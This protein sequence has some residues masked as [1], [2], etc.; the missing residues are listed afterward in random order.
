MKNNLKLHRSSAVTSNVSSDSIFKEKPTLKIFCKT[1]R[2]PIDCII[3]KIGGGFSWMLFLISPI[4]FFA[5]PKQQTKVGINQKQNET[6]AK[7]KGISNDSL[8]GF[9]DAE[10]D[11]LLKANQVKGAE[12]QNYINTV[13]RNY[14]NKK[15][16]LLQSAASKTS[17]NDNLGGS[18]Y[19]NPN[20]GNSKTAAPPCVNEGFESSPLGLIPLPQTT[21]GWSV[22]WANVVLSNNCIATSAMGWSPGSQKMFIKSTPLTNPIPAM[23]ALFNGS[24]GNSPLGGTRVAQLHDLSLTN[25]RTRIR[26]TIQVTNLNTLFQF[27]FAGAYE[28]GLHRCCEQPGL[29]VR[30]YDC[31]Q[32]AVPCA[33]LQVFPYGNCANGAGTP[34]KCANCASPSNPSSPD[35]YW[36]NWQSY[37]MDLTPYIGTCVTIEFINSDC[38][39]GGHASTT[40]IDCLCGGPLLATKVLNVGGAINV[41]PTATNICKGSGVTLSASGASSYTWSNQAIN[42]GSS[43]NITVFPNANTTYVVNANSNGCV[44]SKNVQVNVIPSVTVNIGDSGTNICAGKCTTLTALSNVVATTFTWTAPFVTNAASIVACPNTTTTYSLVGRAPNGCRGSQ[45]KTVTVNPAPVVTASG[46]PSVICAGSPATVTASGANT[47]NWS[48]ISSSS[49]VVQVF[50]SAT[51]VYTATGTGTNGCSSTATV[52]IN[53]LVTPTAVIQPACICPGIT[54]TLIGMGGMTYTWYVGGTSPATITGATFTMN[55]NASTPFTL[56]ASGANGCKACTAAIIPTCGPIPLVAP[57]VTLC[58]NAGSCTNIAVNTAASPVNFTWLGSAINGSANG[59]TI[60]ICPSVAGVY[61]VNASSTS[62]AG[63]PNSATLAVTIASNCCSQPTAGLTQLSA[64][65]GSL[66]GSFLLNSS[67]SL[68]GSTWFKDA[69]IWIT[70]NVSLKI[71]PGKKLYLDKVHLYACGIKMW[72]GIIVMDGGLIATSSATV[73]RPSNNSMIEDAKIAIQLDNISTTNTWPAYPID[74]QNVIFNKNHIGIKISNSAVTLDSLA[75]RINGCVF[76]SRTMTFT[77]FPNP[78]LSWPS[79]IITGPADLRAP[80][81]AIAGLS[82][83]YLLNNFAQTNLKL[84]YN[85]IPG[86][87]GIKIENIGDPNGFVPKP[88]VMIGLNYSMIY[89]YNFNLFDG[90]GNGIDVKDASLTT[91]NN[92]FQ[93]MGDYPC[94]TCPTLRYGGNGIYHV[95]T[96][97]MNSR[98]SAKGSISTIDGS[99]FWDC[100]NGITAKNVYEV[101][102]RYNLFRSTHDCSLAFTQFPVRGENGIDYE[103][104]RFKF[105]VE[106][107]QFNNL[108]FGINFKTPSSNMPYDMTG[109]VS[110]FGVYANNLNFQRNYFGALVTSTAAYAGGAP[111]MPSAQ[112][113]SDA[114]TLNTPN[115]SAWSVALDPATNNPYM[116]VI[117]AN[118]VDRTFRG[119]T[120]NSF[121]NSP[122]TVGG[123][124]IYVENDLTFGSPQQG[125]GIAALNNTG[126]LTI[127]NNTVQAA[128]W[129]NPPFNNS[130]SA[131]YCNQNTGF[132]SPAIQCNFVTGSQ[133]GFLF[134]GQNPNSV[135]EAN[136]MCSN[137]AGMALINNGVIGPQGS[138]SLG[139]G[140]EW[141]PNCGPW[142]FPWGPSYQETYVENSDP[143]L[144]PLFVWQPPFNTGFSPSFNAASSGNPFP[145]YS[146]PSTI[147]DIAP[148]NT[149]WDCW[150]SYSY[151]PVPNWRSSAS[152]KTLNEELNENLIKL[153]PNPTNG[154]VTLVT[155]ISGPVTV[156]VMDLAGREL[157]KIITTGDQT[158][159]DLSEF[160][161]AVYIIELNRNNKIIRKKLIKISK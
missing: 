134:D 65:S 63:C 100:I 41:V 123:N 35:I 37:S 10:I 91:Q 69:E 36:F 161:P 23:P 112:Y 18:T 17:G 148:L 97:L 101:T 70:E 80:T 2:K 57:N 77:T 132:Q 56:C 103:S 142:L 102:V 20:A 71:P 7:I 15:Y 47:Y 22:D 45:T 119:I 145:P 130:L 128:P 118:R 141:E 92:V 90:L 127:Q 16:H 124:S 5:Q 29:I 138:P 87:T 110:N 68:S 58:S 83:P 67:Q 38:A 131:V 149:G 93:N 82:A 120:I 79:N 143:S 28:D 156:R 39:F 135:W 150:V 152:T 113:L 73:G 30:L 9:N 24:L 108:K 81:P 126:N 49:S 44:I 61:I 59:A 125:Y 27:A 51:T 106:Q 72:D 62:T 98:L 74:I 116:S 140:N 95:I 115:T 26:Q 64:I 4:M 33:S 76:S 75:L 137:W 43:A 160:A 133:Y 158:E 155:G 129:Y 54:N 85:T 109:T 1:K 34:N 139:S 122:L 111:N 31:N 21:P 89:K 107:S 13:R 42:I 19:A 144:S 55:L 50:P 12:Y 78:V 136:H 14:I 153:F 46:S 151:P 40:F 52:A 105:S 32:N 86:Q 8:K 117:N 157:M 114:I 99:L 159:L 53:V 25:S 146:I 48:P 121:E 94:P 88:G 84:P 3:L 66:T 11:A 154:K 60:N 147:L 96:G 6:S 104:N